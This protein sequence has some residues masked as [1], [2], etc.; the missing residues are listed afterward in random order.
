[1]VKRLSVTWLGTLFSC[2]C[3]FIGLFLIV[4]PGSP[5]NDVV[6]ADTVYELR[7]AP[8]EV[9]PPRR[10]MGL[11]L[12]ES[13]TTSSKT[14]VAP[15]SRP[16]SN[17]P[18]LIVTG[19]SNPFGAYYAEILRAE[20]LNLFAVAD[21]EHLTPE[22]LASTDVV[23]LTISHLSSEKVHQLETWVRAGGNLIAIR[24][25]GNLLPI[26]GIG[27]AGDSILDGYML[28][29]PGFE[30]GQGIVQES[31]Q[32]RVP[33]SRFELKDSVGVAH[34]YETATR[35][36]GSAA[37][38][39]RTIERGH[40]A[41]YAYDLAQSVIRTRQGNPAWINQE[42]DGLPPRRANDLFFPDYVDM[43][44]IGIPQADEQQR[45]FA[46]L[47]L[48]MNHARRPL[49]R[50][51]YLPEGKR[52]AIILASDDHGTKQG[53]HKAFAKLKDESPTGCRIEAWECYRATSYLTRG[54]AMT[55]D[56]VK[57]YEASGFEVGVHADTGCKDQDTAGVAL[58]VAEQVSAFGK[59]HLGISKQETH[60]LHCIAWN[61]WADT[62]KIER[63]HGIRLSLNY[64]YWPGS[65]IQGR[66]GFMTGSGLPM[67]FADLDGK[68]LDIYQAATHIVDENGI[69]YATGI[70][71]MIDKALGPEQFFGMF[72]TH[73][74]F[75]DDFLSTAIGIAKER[76]VA[77]ISAAQALRWLDAKGSSR[78]D[79]LAW[80]QGT[81]AFDVHVGSETETMTAMVP[82]WSSE[83][84]IL[85]IECDGE[86][87]PYQTV[88][89]KGLE[90]AS[91]P[92]RSGSCKAIY[93]DRSSSAWSA[94]ER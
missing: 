54:T 8:E 62:V 12:A 77:L 72:G 4:G 92:V 45:F 11:K 64:Y 52:A 68:V 24:P 3:L 81:L 91:L 69:E 9:S 25:E 70:R 14:A 56:Q 53:T 50:F 33:A 67:R 34:L 27:S 88:R 66:Q 2:S 60:R 42:R 85:A 82:M 15:Q 61:G 90:Y 17:A 49:P 13:L 6:P 31:L 20:G 63:D 48:T 65:W 84:R 94:P 40:A 19:E 37:V 87:K 30:P 73:Y 57:R 79:Q 39:L 16:P 58:A 83:H 86:A 44:K 29:D 47:I 28:V 18:V 55:P 10:N 41:A 26:L 38:T 89:I 46:N 43:N 21:V 35:P 1:M 51:W 78:F 36:L 80:D 5:T 59:Q 23:I 22:R 7:V 71:F 75:R 93:G 76:G 74:D 32:L